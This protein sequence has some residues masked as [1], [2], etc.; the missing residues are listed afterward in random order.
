MNF[1]EAIAIAILQGITELFPISSLGH[2]VV[3]PA[4]FLPGVDLRSPAF[5]PFLVVL[6]LG[7][8]TALLVYFWRDW[9]ELLIGV[10][11]GGRDAQGENRRRLLALIVVGTIPAVVLGF[12][13]E[14]PL[15]ALFGEPR[16]A[17]GFLIANG[18]LLAV[19]EML[20]K[21]SIA[22]EAELREAGKL[23][24]LGAVAVGF[25]QCLAFFPGIS[26]SGATM[27]GGILA[28]LT[29]EQAARFSFL[30]ATPVIAGAS[31][32]EI[33]KL[34]RGG[35]AA[36]QLMPLSTVLAG[37][38]AAGIAAYASVAFLMHYFRKHDF[39]ALN[40]FAIYCVVFGGI[41]L[42]FLNG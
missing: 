33:P 26:R 38:V 36:G 3:L 34:L 2:A 8:A 17:A 20:R 42:Y 31:V 10:F 7:T 19:G 28:K 32:L 22:H 5:L 39:S 29:H 9:L 11:F 25:W 37:G 41:S 12:A 21:R 40:P 30:L 16:I 24:F 27:V 15:R 23:S 13:F 4:L 18:A 6:H 1:A 14:K 35:S